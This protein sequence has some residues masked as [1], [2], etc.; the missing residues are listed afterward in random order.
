MRGAGGQIILPRVGLRGVGGAGLG[1]RSV[2]VRRYART[3][4]KRDGSRSMKRGVVGVVIWS[5]WNRMRPASVEL[6]WN[7]RVVM[8]VV[9]VSPPTSSWMRSGWGSCL[10]VSGVGVLRLRDSS[11]RVS[12]EEVRVGVEGSMSG[13]VW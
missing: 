5:L 8:E 4:L 3:I 9:K 12:M 10:G 6:V 13:K 7:V 1:M 2:F 11:V